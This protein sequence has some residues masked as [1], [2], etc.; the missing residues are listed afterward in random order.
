[1]TE[2]EWLGS[3]YPLNLLAYVRAGLEDRK[4]LL[5]TAACF[6]RHW[7]RLPEAGRAFTRL[8]KAAAGGKVTRRAFDGFEA[9]MNELGPPSESA[10][11]VDLAYGMWQADPWDPEVADKGED[12]TWR[13]ERRAQADLM[14]VLFGNPF[15]VAEAR[16]QDAEPGDVVAGGGL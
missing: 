16:D 12:E 5:L 10:A 8:A 11:L 9:A 7:D 13:P 6:R 4:T 2:A 3:E 1:V 14:R 15:R